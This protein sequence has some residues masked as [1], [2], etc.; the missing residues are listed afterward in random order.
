MIGGIDIV[1]LIAALMAASTPVLLAA[2][3]ELVAEKAGVLNL[4][5]EGMMIVGAVAGFA[6]AV[7]TGSPVLGFAGGALAGALLAC[8]FA[9]LT[10]EFSMV[11]TWLPV[12]MA[13]GFSALIGLTFGY[14]PARRAAR[15]NPP[16]ALARE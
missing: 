2:T 14:F 5:V 11:F 15:L 1:T 12:A 4:G 10:Q 7:T 8:L 13:C 3:G 6:M 9:L 16:E